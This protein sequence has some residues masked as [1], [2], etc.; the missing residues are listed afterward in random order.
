MKIPKYIMQKIK[1]RCD[2]Q[3]KANAL[4]V[5]IE[6]WCEKKGIDIGEYQCTHICL[7]TEPLMVKHTH[8]NILEMI[9]K[10]EGGE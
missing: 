4:Q 10:S 5:E 9:E 2:A 6:E 7:Y 8:I 1:A 3:V